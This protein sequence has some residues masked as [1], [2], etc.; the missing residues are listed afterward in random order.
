MIKYPLSRPHINLAEE[1]AIKK[2][3]RSGTLSLG[4]IT[5]DF[6]NA[7]AQKLGVKYSCAV[8]SGTAA[9]HLALIAAGIGK[10]DE[11]ITTPFSFVASANAILYV[12]AKPVFVDIDPATYNIDP[13]RIEPK[14]TEKTKAI[15]VVHIFGQTANMSF[16]SNL[17]KKYKLKIIEDACESIMAKHNNRNVGTF[18]ES[19]VFSF[20][21]NKQMTTGEGGMITTNRKSIYDLCCSLRN[22]GRTKNMQWLDHRRLGYNYRMSEINAALGLAQLKKLDFAISERR[23]IVNNYNK[24]L[25]PYKN[26][27]QTPYIAPQN[28]HTFFLYIIKLL[29]RKTNR[30]KVIT[31]LAGKGVSSKAYLPSIHLYD[32]YRKKFGYKRSDFPISENTSANTLALPLYIGLKE[33]DIKYITRS[34]ITCINNG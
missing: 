22:Q 26:L 19:A 29:T 30:D 8:S 12:D 21:P 9:L 27:L 11:V 34:L 17:A 25:A 2:V 32:F 16:I 1:I 31:S 23:R 33:N 13:L 18:G 15:L 28:T 3:L 5:L 14:I 24:Y 4:P 10:G 20:Y 7:F 6:E